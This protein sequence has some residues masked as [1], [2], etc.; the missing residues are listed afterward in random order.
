MSEFVNGASWLD[1]DPPFPTSAAYG[2]SQDLGGTLSLIY[3][4]ADLHADFV[5]LPAICS[6]AYDN[7]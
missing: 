4:S 5:S 3:R 7:I 2:G 1:L 6:L